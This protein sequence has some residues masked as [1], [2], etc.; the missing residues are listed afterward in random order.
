MSVP[1]SASISILPVLRHRWERLGGLFRCNVEVGPVIIAHLPLR[2][3]TLFLLLVACVDT[4]GAGDNPFLFPRL[5]GWDYRHPRLVVRRWVI[6][7]EQARRFL[8]AVSVGL[9]ILS[10]ATGRLSRERTVK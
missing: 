2:V 10:V 8:L 5:V 7:H 3:L 4:T 6:D 9:V 1:V